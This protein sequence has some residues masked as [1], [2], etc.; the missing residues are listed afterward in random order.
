[1]SR[2][3][4]D[5]LGGLAL[6]FGALSALACAERGDGP[7]VVVSDSAGVPVYSLSELPAW[8]DPAFQWELLLE[9]SIPTGADSP[10][11]VPLVYQPQGYA[12]LPDGTLVVLDGAPSRLV[13]LDRARDEVIR[14]FGPS[15][16]GPGEVWSSNSTIWPASEG[17]FW[18]LDPGNQRLSRFD[19]SGALE[20]EAPVS[21][22][23][24]AGVV[25]QD[26][27][28][29]A[30]WFWK[31][32]IEDEEERTLVDSIG[33]LDS[34]SREVVFVAPMAPRVEGRRRSLPGRQPEL[35]APMGWF[36]PLGRDVVVAGRSDSGRF[37][38]YSGEGSL[39][40]V[41]NTPLV[42]AAIAESEKPRILEEY[43]GVAGSTATR[44][45]REV[46][47]SYRLYDLMWGLGDSLF[48][49]QQSHLSTP[50]G[51]P[52]ITAGQMVWRVFSTRGKYRGVIVL[53]P[54]V[55]QPYWIESGRI[56]ATHRDE[57]GV[58]SIQQFRLVQPTLPRR[59]GA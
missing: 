4:V 1:M 52:R 58:A 22:P 39:V 51:E 24:M 7:L 43:F 41:I 12:R 35:M 8:D 29:H 49:L 21:I 50:E 32:F 6:S 56:V 9:R 36:A 5:L 45:A 25:F 3:K 48:A 10:D 30:P 14:R 18:V 55:A 42:P 15:G 59:P 57:L 13:V 46:G 37:R 31:V 16:Q 33:R 19:L 20:E 53:P 11:D 17:S 54:G 26:P 44:E 34:E 27:V 40:G 47:G 38:V 23:G 28:D 2:M